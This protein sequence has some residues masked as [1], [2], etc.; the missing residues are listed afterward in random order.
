[1]S[2]NQE[3][4]IDSARLKAAQAAFSVSGSSN[5]CRKVATGIPIY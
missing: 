2:E 4:P 1:M 5:L 3:I